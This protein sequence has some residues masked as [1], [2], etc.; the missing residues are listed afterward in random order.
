MLGKYRGLHRGIR[1]QYQEGKAIIQHVVACYHCYHSGHLG[2][3]PVGN[4]E[5][6][7][8]HMLQ[9]DPRELGDLN[10]NSP[11]SLVEG[12]LEKFNSLAF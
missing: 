12:S 1:L 7:C 10:S 5:K 9:N 4:S 6:W 11:E 2:L 8:K 3:N